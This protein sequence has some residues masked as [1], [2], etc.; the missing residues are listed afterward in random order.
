APDLNP[1]A[2]ITRHRPLFEAMGL[3]LGRDVLVHNGLAGIW[4]VLQERGQQPG[5]VLFHYS[6]GSRTATL[7]PW[8]E[9]VASTA[10]VLRWEYLH[11]VFRRSRPS[12]SPSEELAE[13]Y[14]LDDD[15]RREEQGELDFDHLF[16]PAEATGYR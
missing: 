1:V 8:L 2:V 12:P 6:S 14:G 10:P 4:S 9:E 16:A 15:P 11:E 7:E 5:L 3:E 13:L